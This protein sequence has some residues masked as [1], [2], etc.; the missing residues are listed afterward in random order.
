[1]SVQSQ[2]N[3]ITYSGNDVITVFNYPFRITTADSLKV[4]LINI[5]TGNYTEQILNTNYTVT[6]VNNVNG[7]TVVFHVAPATGYNVFIARLNQSYIQEMS[8]LPNSKFDLT[9]LEKT[10]DRFA[11]QDQQLNLKYNATIKLSPYETNG[12]TLAPP[13]VRKDTFFAFDGVGNI[14]YETIPSGTPTDMFIQAGTGAVERTYQNKVRERI[15]VADY[16]ALGDGAT[17]ETTQL[18]NAINALNVLGGGILELGYTRH[19]VIESALTIYSNITIRGNGSTITQLS[20]NQNIISGTNINNIC[21]TDCIFNGNGTF[22]SSFS[23]TIIGIYISGSNSNIVINNNKIMGCNSGIRISFCSDVVINNNRII[24]CGFGGIRTEFCNNLEINANH[25]DN[26][27]GGPAGGIQF[28]DGIYFDACNQVVVSHNKISR[29]IRMGIVLESSNPVSFKNTDFIISNNIIRE[30]TGSIAPEWNGGIWLEGNKSAG[31]ITITNNQIFYNN[32]WSGNKYLGI[33]ASNGAIVSNNILRSVST[34]LVD[35][36][37]IVFSN[38]D[39]EISNNY[40][41]GFSFGIYNASQEASS[42]GALYTI[43]NNIIRECLHSGIYVYRCG[44]TFFIENNIIKDCGVGYTIEGSFYAGAGIRIESMAGGNH[45][46]KYS[47]KSNTFISSVSENATSGQIYGVLFSRAAGGN[48]IAGCLSFDNNTFIYN[49]AIS[50]PYPDNLT[51]NSIANVIP[52]AIARDTG[53]GSVAQRREIIYDRSHNKSS[54]LPLGIAGTIFPTISDPQGGG[55][56]RFVG[57]GSSAP[58]SGNYCQGDY[59]YN[60]AIHELGS[61]GAKYTIL[62]WTCISNGSPGTWVAQRMPTGD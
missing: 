45:D 30:L 11:L 42:I 41:N 32:T 25:I 54:K 6:D 52:I 5:T 48:E 59:I 47:I 26:I 15:S 31:I 14:S 60:T 10:L 62:G 23:N 51:F 3:N 36:G 21:I 4:L 57:H 34:A 61:V 9:S 55:A 37:A 19:Y 50:T 1:M 46:P 38:G 49:G 16:N 44:T 7:G 8:F 58:T 2:V 33:R 27:Q 12:L 17:P 35:G 13:S 39:T 53:A 43:K 18:Q 28:G 24:D 29:C 40:I 56:P 22:S 20:I